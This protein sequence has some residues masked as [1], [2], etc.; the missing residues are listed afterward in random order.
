MFVVCVL[1]L[2]FADVSNRNKSSTVVK[3]GNTFVA[4]QPVHALGLSEYYKNNRRVQQY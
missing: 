4:D 2:T 1:G 3:L